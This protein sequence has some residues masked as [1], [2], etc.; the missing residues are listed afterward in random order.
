M[1]SV[2][3]YTKRDTINKNQ[4]EMKVTKTEMSDAVDGIN[5]ILD[6]AENNQQF[7]R[8]DSGKHSIKTEK[9][10]NIKKRN[11][12]EPPGKLQAL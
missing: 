5:S 4:S 8:Q 7:G 12:K 3:T 1:E 9:K 6:K 10:K 11:F 2:R